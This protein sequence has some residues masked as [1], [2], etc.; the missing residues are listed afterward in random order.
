MLFTPQQEAILEKISVFLGSENSN[1][2][3]NV[4]VIT[5]TADTDKLALVFEACQQAKSYRELMA[6]IEKSEFDFTINYSG[7]THMHTVALNNV[8]KEQITFVPTA[9]HFIGT[10]N[11][12]TNAVTW[13][14]EPTAPRPKG[15]LFVVYGSENMCETLFKHSLANTVEDSLKKKMI[16]IHDS[17]NAEHEY[18]NGKHHV[19]MLI[20]SG[21]FKNV[22]DV[23]AQT[24]GVNRIPAA[25]RPLFDR[26]VSA[27]A[28]NTPLQISDL[29]E[30]KLPS[31]LVSLIQPKSAKSVIVASSSNQAKE[32]NNQIQ[33]TLTGSIYPVEGDFI[34]TH[35]MIHLSPLIASIGVKRLAQVVT[36]KNY[37]PVIAERDEKYAVRVHKYSLKNFDHL[38]MD[39]EEIQA[40]VPDDTAWFFDKIKTHWLAGEH[41]DYHEARIYFSNLELAYAETIDYR[42]YTPNENVAYVVNNPVL[43]VKQLKEVYTLLTHTTADFKFITL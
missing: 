38:H 16:L 1:P 36:S 32:L 14:R 41:K 43:T 33:A 8:C 6:T 39:E 30:K 17:R 24:T 5:G 21:A 34:R 35:S 10:R 3:D 15:D 28:T 4:L 40:I 12:E 9:L 27:I 37:V 31:E 11:I 23:S 2:L 25:L 20:D 26:V 13:E 22:I 7:V 42:A 29:V 19:Q 18:Q